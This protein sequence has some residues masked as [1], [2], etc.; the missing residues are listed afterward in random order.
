MLH[1]RI[2]LMYTFF[3]NPTV[4]KYSNFL[5][6]YENNLFWS[7]VGFVAIFY[8]TVAIQSIT[9][10]PL[11]FDE[12]WVLQAPLTMAT[13]GEYASLGAMWG[14]SNKLFDPYV[15]SGPAVLMPIALSF[16]L[17]GVGVVQA[18]IIMVAFYLAVIFLMAWY[19]HSQTKSK[20]AL[21]AV[22]S[23]LLLVSVPLNF[24]LD[25]LGE[26]PAIAYALASFICWQ[27]RRFGLAGLF[28][29][30]AVLSKIIM[31]FLLA[32]AVLLFVY[33]FIRFAKS[34]KSTCIHAC[35]WA[36]GAAIPI[37]AWEIF[38]F[39]QL[40]S[41]AAYKLNWIEYIGFFKVTGS[42]LSPNGTV[43][44]FYDK[45]NL[46]ISTISIQKSLLYIIL[47][48]LFGLIIYSTYKKRIWPTIRAQ[49]YA[50]TFVALYLFW[51][52][53]KSN[54]GFARYVVPVSAVL[55]AVLISLAF[56]EL[57][58]PGKYELATRISA[59]FVIFAILAVGVYKHIPTSKPVYGFTLSQQQAVASE[60]IASKPEALSHLGFWQNPEIL[61][62]TNIHSQEK[63]LRPDKSS[64]QLLIS[65]TMLD[66]APADYAKA[67]TMCAR[68]IIA[69]RGGYIFCEATNNIE[70]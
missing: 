69:P 2:M 54:G 50:L 12:G 23:I 21:L 18:R 60:I 34:R 43:L 30:L 55:I 3:K 7:G 11:G 20:Y 52:F 57:K 31:F 46:L 59:G 15:S 51:W 29:A 4:K 63:G 44:T 22:L 41:Y 16:K 70:L 13:T 64:I 58:K 65:G 48:L 38:K 10:Q 6:R 62:L 36:V 66:N 5:K 1:D 33:T 25:I 67:K 17:F 40:G 56:S 14:G 61:F 32:A 28:A 68:D 53:A 24:R 47:G 39:V 37:V 27:K 9:T 42:G 8:L 35:R 45:F 26:F 19:V 49:Q